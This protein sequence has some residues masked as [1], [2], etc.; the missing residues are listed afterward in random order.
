MT[1]ILQKLTLF[2]LLFISLPLFAQQIQTSFFEGFEAEENNAQWTLNH[3]ANGPNMTNKWNIS[4]YEPFMGDNCLIISDNDGKTPSY[5]NVKNTVVAFREYLLPPGAYNLSFMWRCGGV[6]ASHGFYVCWAPSSIDIKSGFAGF[7]NNNQAL[8]FGN[9]KMLNNS[10][11]WTHQ[12][13]TV[14]VSSTAGTAPRAYRLYFVWDNNTNATTPSPAACIDNVQLVSTACT[15]PDN[16]TSVIS[17]NDLTLTWTGIAQSYDIMYRPY[18]SSDTTV[19]GGFT[20]NRYKFTGLEQ[21]VYD[22]WVRSICGTDTSIWAVSQNH[23]IYNSEVNCID[24]ID[25]ASPNTLCQI[26]S[27]KDPNTEAS[28][29]D[30]GSESDL[31]RHTMNFI[32]GAMDPWSTDGQLPMVAPGELVSV[33]LGNPHTGGEQESVT[34]TYSVGAN[35]SVILMLNY[36][37]VF[38]EPGHDKENYFL[39]ELLDENDQLLEPKNDDGQPI[40]GASRSCSLTEFHAPTDTTSAII[41]ATWH[42]SPSTIGTGNCRWKDWTKV[43]INLSNFRGQTVKVRISTFDCGLMA[44][45]TYAYYTISCARAEMAG[46]SCGNDTDFAVSAPEGFRYKWYRPNAPEKILSTERDWSVPSS[47]ADTFY[48]NVISTEDSTCYFTLPAYLVPTEPFS[49]F[50]PKWMPANCENRILL[51][52]TSG[53]MRDGRL[54]KDKCDYTEWIITD[55]KTNKSDTIT[56]Q[57]SPLIFAPNE[58]AEY[59]VKLVSGMSNNQCTDTTPI[60]IV[61]VPAIGVTDTTIKVSTC[62]IPYWFGNKKYDK[63]GIYLN[64][65]DNVSVAGCDSIVRLDLTVLEK[66]DDERFDTICQGESYDLNGQRYTVSGD[67]KARIPNE[68]GCDT[69]VLLHLLVVP[70]V[71]VAFNPL[72]PICADDEKFVATFNYDDTQGKIEYYSLTFD[73]LA[74]K[75]GFHDVSR[76]PIP[77]DGEIHINMPSVYGGAIPHP[78]NYTV[79]VTFARE[80]CSD[81][82]FD[83]PFSVYYPVKGIMEQKWNN[84][85]ALLNDSN[86]V[87]RYEYSHYQWFK[88][89][90]PIVGATASYLYL[91]SG[92]SFDFKEEYSVRLVREGESKGIM[93]CPIVPVDRTSVQVS[94]FDYLATTILRAAQRLSLLNVTKR[95]VAS[96]YS[97]SGQKVGSCVVDEYSTDITTPAQSGIYILRL[98]FGTEWAVYKISIK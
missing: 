84:V 53:I 23:L 45:Y 47:Q 34:Y 85:I 73:T 6:E 68:L 74:I 43:G 33:R 46:Y 57:Y 37:V 30:F 17:K 58:G 20:E 16:I 2:I 88:N 36:A 93:S 70:S 63:T 9:T 50:I 40:I 64:D 21:G 80:R 4:D 77:S 59:E 89:D 8:T 62:T 18:G 69:M 42:K 52:N 90:E 10:S 51:E 54:S 14:T 35:E 49:S 55:K 26:G 27:F 82:V 13:T 7:T 25:F 87:Y 3:G 95:G 11:R 83:L 78:D 28:I 66:V 39:V 31:S 79:T 94:E 5:K 96:W 19:V 81:L 48:C 67:Y 71:D 98:D 92:E 24:F 76:L 56:N 44:H 65:D 60:T 32:P 1:S 72:S 29:V 15:P 75:N 41:D 12:T 22:F 61:K 91:G 86:N 97:V 38:N